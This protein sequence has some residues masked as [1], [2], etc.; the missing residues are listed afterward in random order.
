MTDFKAD[1]LPLLIGSLP[2]KDHDA[3][4]RLILEFT[5]EVPL[6]AQLPMFLEEGMAAQF[7]PGMPGFTESPEGK[8]YINEE[9]DTFD[10]EYLAFYEEYLA[11]TEAGASLD[12]S[13]FALTPATGR[14]FKEFMRQ[15]DQDT[16]GFKALKGQVTGPFTFATSVTDKEGRAIFYNDQLRDAAIK[17]LAMN[18]KWQARTFASRDLTPIIFFDE[19]ALAGFGT[20]AFITVSRQEV[21]E[22]INEVMAAVHEEGGLTGI[23]VCANTEWDLLLDSKID[24]INFDAYSYFDKFILYPEKIKN[25][26]ARGGI[27]AWGIVPTD[28][29][30]D[31]AK[32]TCDTL[33]EMLEAQFAQMEAIGIDRATLL[34]QSFITPSCGTGSI[35]LDSA[36]RVLM[37]TR[38]LSKRIRA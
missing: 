34:S 14:G 38:D 1:A 29:A 15:V 26:I 36:K 8:L 6:W 7:L 31:I 16:S 13:R 18:A 17:H 33:G 22:A 27:I 20:S 24:I 21:T 4:T 11:V 30:D 10:A 32:E 5:P 12:D 2:M 28:N 23:H 9:S 37:L 35:D 25:F 3:A 19:P